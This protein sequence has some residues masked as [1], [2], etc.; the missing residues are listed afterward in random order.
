MKVEPRRTTRTRPTSRSVV[1]ISIILACA[2]LAALAHAAVP[3]PQAH[4]VLFFR[5][6]PPDSLLERNFIEL[7]SDLRGF[8]DSGY[9][10][11]GIVTDASVRYGVTEVHQATLLDS[12]DSRRQPRSRSPGT[13]VL[14]FDPVYKVCAR[15]YSVKIGE[16]SRTVTYIDAHDGKAYDFPLRTSRPF[17]IHRVEINPVNVMRDLWEDWHRK[18]G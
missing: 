7:A 16:R 9:P 3:D 10:P 4:L 15:V 14:E 8:V 18:R 13:Y 6:R 12:T 5:A 17:R 1:A 2:L 11:A